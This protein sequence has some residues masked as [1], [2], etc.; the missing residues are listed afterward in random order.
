MMQPRDAKRSAHFKLDR[1][2]TFTM[3]EVLTQ[4]YCK[5]EM[6]VLAS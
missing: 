4:N 6:L 3:Y 1:P 5:T 2:Q